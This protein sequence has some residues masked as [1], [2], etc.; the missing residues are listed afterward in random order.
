MEQRFDGT[1]NI[2]V[3]DNT[4][5]PL[6]GGTLTGPLLGT[7]FNGITGLSSTAPIVDGVATIGVATTAAKADHIHP[8]QTTVTGNAGTPTTLQ[9]GRTISITGDLIYTSPAF[10]GAANITAV[11]TLQLLV[12]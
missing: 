5:L 12:V 4:K 8:A 7:S 11:G 3:E 1:A 10:T 2:T 6:A 9:T